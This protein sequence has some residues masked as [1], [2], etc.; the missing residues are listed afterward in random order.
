M[1]KTY[2]HNRIKRLVLGGFTVSYKYQ[3]HPNES[4]GEVRI[5]VFTDNDIPEVVVDGFGGHVWG[6]EL[7][8]EAVD[9]FCR[10]VLTKKNLVYHDKWSEINQKEIKGN[11]VFPAKL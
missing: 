1:K 4:I 2:T 5:D 10:K 7:V 6:V 8:D 11:R 3:E 9:F